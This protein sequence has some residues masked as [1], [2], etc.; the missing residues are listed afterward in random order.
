LQPPGTMTLP[1][2]IY[3]LM[4]GNGED[5]LAGIVLVLALAYLVVGLA[6]IALVG[7]W[8]R[9]RIVFAVVACIIAIL[10]GALVFWLLTPHTARQIAFEHSVFW[11]S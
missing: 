11:L 10:V 7:A 8:Q 6:C 9:S 1:V 3:Q 4:H 5:R 2:E